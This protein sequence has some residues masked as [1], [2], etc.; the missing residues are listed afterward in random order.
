MRGFLR[1]QTFP[2]CR[3][4]LRLARVPARNVYIHILVLYTAVGTR[5]I[6]PALFLFV[7]EIVRLIDLYVYMQ[8]SRAFEIQRLADAR[9]FMQNMVL[10]VW[11]MDAYIG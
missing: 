1:A 10:R 2:G 8:A 5:P 9:F 6:L 11:V 4:L 3:C 7:I